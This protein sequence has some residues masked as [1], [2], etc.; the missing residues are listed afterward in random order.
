MVYGVI[1]AAAS[2][3]SKGMLITYINSNNTMKISRLFIELMWY[4]E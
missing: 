1:K 4:A 3:I 2:C